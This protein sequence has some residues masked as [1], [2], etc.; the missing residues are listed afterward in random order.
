MRRACRSTKR[1]NREMEERIRV[2]EKQIA[3]QRFVM[4]NLRNGIDYLKDQCSKGQ[5]SGIRRDTSKI[6]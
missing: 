2:N 4:N 6:N 1:A 3:A 5:S